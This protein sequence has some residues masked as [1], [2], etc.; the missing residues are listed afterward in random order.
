MSFE[1][2]A[3]SCKTALVP[4]RDP[5]EEAA[6]AVEK[7][8]GTDPVRGEDL[9]ASEELKRKF[10]EAKRNLSSPERRNAGLRKSN[11]D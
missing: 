8:T 10:R 9:V 5:N 3:R 2:S 11:R 1:F 4:E 6:R 7:I